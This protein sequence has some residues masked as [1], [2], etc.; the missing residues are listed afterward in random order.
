MAE[1]NNSMSETQLV[2]F[3]LASECYGV[4]IS[5]VR[6][7]MRMQNI[8][9][10]PGA[11]SYVEGVINLRGKVLPVLDLRKRLSLTIG[12]QTKD[13][14]VVVIDIAAGEVG[15][16]VDAVSEVLRIPN[17]AVEPPSSMITQANSDYLMGIARLTDRLIILL[18]LNKLLSTGMAGTSLAALIKSDTVP[19]EKEPEEIG[20]N[21]AKELATV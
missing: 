14:R 4:D 10:V 8:T 18:D 9:R 12:A 19:T 2:V 21:G 17:S 16:I 13:S 1:G 20:K 7:I 11:L 6:E 15:V 3:D 5:S